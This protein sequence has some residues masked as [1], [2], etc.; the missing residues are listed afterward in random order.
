M[1]KQSR[2]PAPPALATDATRAR[3]FI[4]G[5]EALS[6]G[7]PDKAQG[8]VEELLDEL[9]ELVQTL[10]TEVVGRVVARNRTPHMRFLVGTGKA[11]EIVSQAQALQ[12]DTI[13]FDEPLSPSQQRNWEKLAQCR[14]IDREEVILDIFGRRAQTREAVLQVSLA[15]AQYNLPRLTR[16]WSHLSQQRGMRGGMGGRGEGEQQIELDY[17]MVKSRITRLKAEL[18]EVR[19]RRQ[20]Q[21]QKRVKANIP[22]TALVG[23]TNTGKSALLNALTR[24]GVLVEDKLFATLDPTL[25]RLRLPQRQEVLVSDTVGF[26]RKLPHT[27]V[28]SFKSTLESVTEADLL[29]LILDVSSTQVDAHHATTEAVLRELGAECQPTLTVFNKI[30]LVTDPFVLQRLRRQHHDAVFISA[31]TGAGLEQL[32]ERL[33]ELLASRLQRVELLLP[34]SRHDLLAQLFRQARILEQVYCDDG[35]RVLAAIPPGLVCAVSAYL[36]ES[37]STPVSTTAEISS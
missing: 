16:R 35:I 36:Q 22:L 25:R 21:R 20:V 10:N 28:E 11:Q 13:I 33:M 14:V 9:Q 7:P 18:A 31:K 5:V 30:D 34:H 37:G 29:L 15:Q 6:A 12:A 17:R 1:A 26:I 4:V 3:A 27:L 2:Q 23:Y 19:L 8:S 32:L 24:A